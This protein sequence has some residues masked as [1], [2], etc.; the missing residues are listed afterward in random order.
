[1]SDRSRRLAGLPG[2]R[3]DPSWQYALLGGLLAACMIVALHW[4]SPGTI[5]LEPAFVA[6]LVAGYHYEGSGTE[7]GT[8]GGRLGAIGGLGATPFFVEV[9]VAAGA[10]EGPLWFLVAATALVAVPVVGI[11]IGL[12]A[13]VGAI[14]AYL[15]NWLEGRIADRRARTAGA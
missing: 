12:S 11:P 5:R 2:D 10:F 9:V 14:G 15:G 6:A 8:L 1:M 13:A 4:R 3:L 7:V